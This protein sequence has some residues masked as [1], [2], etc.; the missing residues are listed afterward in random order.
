[1]GTADH[2]VLG[3]EVPSAVV[4]PK[5][6][7]N[8]VERRP[9][10]LLRCVANRIGW[11]SR[12]TA[13]TSPR[14]LGGSVR[15]RGEELEDGEFGFN[16]SAVIESQDHGAIR[17]LRGGDTLRRVGPVTYLF[18]T[19]GPDTGHCDLTARMSPPG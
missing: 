11:V 1:M 7:N 18:A 17:G 13:P 6:R 16:L 2:R 15:V 12:L 5:T 10:C 8:Q 4:V 9:N 14:S 3:Q 19:S